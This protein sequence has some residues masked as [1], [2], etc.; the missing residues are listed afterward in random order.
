LV[1]AVVV[2]LVV[3]FEMFFFCIPQTGEV[4]QPVADDCIKL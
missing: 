3:C 1:F 2:V 4:E